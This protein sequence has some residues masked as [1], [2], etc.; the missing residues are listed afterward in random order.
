MR[1]LAA[2]A[3]GAESFGEQTEAVLCLQMAIWQYAQPAWLQFLRMRTAA[4]VVEDM[5]QQC[6]RHAWWGLHCV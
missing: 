2:A 3:L 1:S 4:A 6:I 5:W